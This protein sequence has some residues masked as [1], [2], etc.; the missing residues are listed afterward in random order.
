MVAHRIPYVAQASPHDPRDLMR[1][2]AKAPGHRRAHVPQRPLALPARLA[3]RERRRHR[4][5]RAWPPRP[6][7]GRSS[8]SRTAGTGSPTGPRDKRPAR[9]SGSSPGPVRPLARPGTEHLVDRLQQWV[10]DEWDLLLRKCDEIPEEQWRT[11]KDRRHS[12]LTLHPHHVHE[13]ALGEPL[14]ASMTSNTI[15]W[16]AWGATASAYSWGAVDD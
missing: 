8:R 2:A 10:D 1:K 5:W 14:G 16:G 6:A 3:H 4:C 13:T 7:T 15:D 11:T 9:R 12:R